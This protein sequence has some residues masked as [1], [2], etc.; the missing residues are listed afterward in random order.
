MQPKAT[1]SSRKRDASLLSLAK[2]S[3]KRMMAAAGLR[4]LQ[5]FH[6]IRYKILPQHAPVALPPPSSRAWPVNRRQRSDLKHRVAQ[7]LSRLQA[8]A[9][10]AGCRLGPSLVCPRWGVFL[11]PDASVRDVVRQLAGTAQPLPFSAAAHSCQ[12]GLSND[13]NVLL[14]GVLALVNHGCASGLSFRRSTGKGTDEEWWPRLGTRLRCQ[15]KPSTQLVRV[16]YRKRL[17]ETTIFELDGEREILICYG[18]SPGFECGCL[19]AQC[20]KVV[21]EAAGGPG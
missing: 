20:S 7:H 17:Y 4:S 21:A 5:S 9:T 8:D 13:S 10:L 14:E 15:A 18:Q 16:S 11:N 2:T 3:R 19:S 12:I 6:F 1:T